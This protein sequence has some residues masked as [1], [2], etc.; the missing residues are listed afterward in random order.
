MG[1]HDWPSEVHE[2]YLKVLDERD[3]LTELA[4]KLVVLVRIG[5]LVTV[6]GDRPKLKDI[7]DPDLHLLLAR[8]LVSMN[9]ETAIAAILSEDE[10][11][12]NQ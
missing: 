4:E 7:G 5:F 11:R 12:S 10:D 6:A 9:S 1:S 2:Q 3:R 8:I